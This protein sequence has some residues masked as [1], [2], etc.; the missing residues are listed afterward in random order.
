VS[1]PEVDYD[2]ADSDAGLR[3]DNTSVSAVLAQETAPRSGSHSTGD[4]NSTNVCVLNLPGDVT[5]AELGRHFARYGDVATVKVS[6]PSQPARR[7]AE[8]SGADHVSARS[9]TRHGRRRTQ[10]PRRLRELYASRGRR[11]C[12]AACRRGKVGVKR[13]YAVH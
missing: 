5:E 3:A 9:S 2:S 4:H 7:M 8:R 12:D 11:V 1:L 13:R 10:G 6:F